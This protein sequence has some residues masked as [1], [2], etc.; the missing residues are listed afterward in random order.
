MGVDLSGD[1]TSTH[2]G[3]RAVAAATARES[4]E[5]LPH[6]E[7][8]SQLIGTNLNGLPSVSTLV[9]ELEWTLLGRD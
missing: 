4:Y 9:T 1:W 5:K 7:V 8:N 2:K 6:H 3:K